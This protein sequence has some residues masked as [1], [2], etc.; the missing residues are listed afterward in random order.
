MC[1][2]NWK[3]KT[4]KSALALKYIFPNDMEGLSLY[5]HIKRIWDI[6]MNREKIFSIPIINV[7]SKPSKI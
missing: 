3:K 5:L 1:V 7:W 6:S 2:Q 4:F